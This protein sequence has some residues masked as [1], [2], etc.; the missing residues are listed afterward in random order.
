[1]GLDVLR[2]R[3]D[4]RRRSA[5]A[6][7]IGE[8]RRKVG[9]AAPI[10][11]GSSQ[12]DI[13]EV[14][15]GGELGSGSLG[16]RRKS[17]SLVL[18]EPSFGRRCTVLAVAAFGVVLAVDAHATSVDA[19]RL[20]R[21]RRTRRRREVVGE[22]IALLLLFAERTFAD[23]RKDRRELRSI[24]SRRRRRH[25][26]P[27]AAGVGGI[28]GRSRLTASVLRR[29]RTAVLRLSCSVEDI[30][31]DTAHTVEEDV[32]EGGAN[33]SRATLVEVEVVDN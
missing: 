11:A 4:E 25:L 15:I 10:L 19:L 7:E 13:A 30:R 6:S 12:P 1:V 16:G 20:D 21:P 24:V 3:G 27:A 2:R 18:A 31:A 23:G 26:T 9:F 22:S 33:G 8:E 14:V 5:L 29:G 28:D 32:V 17:G